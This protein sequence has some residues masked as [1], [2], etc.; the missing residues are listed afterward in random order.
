MNGSL[1]WR[2]GAGNRMPLLIVGVWCLVNA[3]AAAELKACIADYQSEPISSPSAESQGQRIVVLAARRQGDTVRFL[4]APWARCIAGMASSQYDLILGVE[5]DQDLQQYIAFP[6]KAGGP[7]PS[8]R[9]GTVEYVLVRK[10]AGH[11]ERGAGPVRESVIVPSSGYGVAR[12][13]STGGA[14]TKAM[15]YGAGRFVS[16]LCR[17]RADMIVLRRGDLAASLAECDPQHTVVI[18]S[19]SMGMADVY[20]GVRRS[21]FQSRPEFAES[22]WREIERLRSSPESSSELATTGHAR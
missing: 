3:A 13:L 17:D 22:I 20:L 15:N 1:N 11:P 7:D 9:L 18:Q 6:E 12:R 16:L 8:R 4:V 2:W 10:A 5:A 19:S 21:L 14:Q